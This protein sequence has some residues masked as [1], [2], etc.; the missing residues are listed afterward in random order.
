MH[1]FKK[2]QCPS[3]GVGSAESLP[4]SQLL[5]LWSH[6]PQARQLPVPVQLPRLNQY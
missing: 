2:V 1:N 4:E 6:Q 5:K 3:L